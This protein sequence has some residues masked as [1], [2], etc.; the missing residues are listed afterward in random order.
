[1]S[2]ILTCLLNWYSLQIYS[3]HPR[4]RLY[5]SALKK[6]LSCLN[7]GFK[8]CCRKTTKVSSEERKS[9]VNKM[10][11]RI[12][13]LVGRIFPKSRELIQF[14]IPRI[15]LPRNNGKNFFPFSSYRDV[16][17][18]FAAGLRDKCVRFLLSFYVMAEQSTW[19][20]KTSWKV[21]LLLAVSIPIV[22]HLCRNR[23]KTKIRKLIWN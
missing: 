17:S 15:F 5:S 21:F 22:W 16:F 1:M 10:H 3:K 12:V 7:M 14:S 4:S 20:M 23:R 2:R 6:S 19:K 18:H 11:M 13:D 8:L 9:F